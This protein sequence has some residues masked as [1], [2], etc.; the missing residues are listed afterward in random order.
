MIATYRR[1][2]E[3][4]SMTPEERKLLETTVT[5]LDK[6]IDAVTSSQNPFGHQVNSAVTFDKFDFDEAVREYEKAKESA[7]AS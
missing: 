5:L 4:E 1:T 7:S 6:L 3:R 2:D